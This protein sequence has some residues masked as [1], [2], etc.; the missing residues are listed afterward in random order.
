MDHPAGTVQRKPREIN[1]MV[2]YALWVVFRRTRS[3]AAV[4][5]GPGEVTEALTT[6]AKGWADEDVTLRGVYDVQGFAPGATVLLWLHAD[7]PEQL[8][9][10]LRQIRRSALGDHLELHWSIV[11][12]HRPAEFNKSHVPAFLSGLD[13]KDYLVL[14]PFNRSYEWYL[15]PEAERREMLVEH[16]SM[17]RGYTGVLTNTVASFALSDFEWVLALES[18]E[19]HDMVDLMRHLRASKAR[20]HVRE[21]TP[22]FTGRRLGFDEFGEVVA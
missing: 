11:G 22:F 14:Y 15:L 12:M 6:L 5:S 8:Q 17:G 20:L 7:D 9:R 4:P 18:D 16:G 2:R 19:L 13:P 3:Q 10:A 21:E 1:E